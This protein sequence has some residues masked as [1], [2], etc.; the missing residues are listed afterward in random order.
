M[1]H[2][3]VIGFIYSWCYKFDTVI[4]MEDAYYTENYLWVLMWCRK[5]HAPET[6]VKR[7][8]GGKDYSSLVLVLVLHYPAR[9]NGGG[10]IQEKRYRPDL[11]DRSGAGPCPLTELVKAARWVPSS[12]SQHH[13]IH[14]RFT[15]FRLFKYFHK[16]VVSTGKKK[17]KILSCKKT[18]FHNAQLNALFRK[19][20]W[21][22]I[23][24]IIGYLQSYLKSTF[25]PQR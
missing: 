6:V 8:E 14:S 10:G 23:Y 4:G 13:I 18:E 21:N 11:N 12:I 19:R 22:R 24:S 9:G 2:M 7:G 17:K 3:I 20:H 1:V 5:V 25:M 16:T 15:P